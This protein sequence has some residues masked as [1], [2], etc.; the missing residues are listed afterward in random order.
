VVWSRDGWPGLNG[1]ASNAEALPVELTDVLP[2]PSGQA[3]YEALID[4]AP[5]E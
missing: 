3:A 5:T 2:V 1:L 4:V